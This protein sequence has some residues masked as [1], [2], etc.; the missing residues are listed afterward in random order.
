MSVINRDAGTTDPP[1]PRRRRHS[2]E[3]RLEQI[4]GNNYPP[5]IFF[6]RGQ[7]SNESDYDDV[8]WSKEQFMRA[9]H[10]AYQMG[11]HDAKREL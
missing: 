4:A 5:D 7:L 2:L 1:P 9:L 8:G 11:R 3:H 10:A 6:Q